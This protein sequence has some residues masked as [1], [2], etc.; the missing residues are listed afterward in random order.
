[1]TK[2]ITLD[3]LQQYTENINTAIDGN[4]IGI[5]KVIGYKN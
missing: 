2:Y 3:N 5:Y 1:M 4:F